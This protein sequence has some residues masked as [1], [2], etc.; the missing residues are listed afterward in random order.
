MQVDLLKA[1]WPAPSTVKTKAPST[2][3]TKKDRDNGFA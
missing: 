2:V 1:S 3:E